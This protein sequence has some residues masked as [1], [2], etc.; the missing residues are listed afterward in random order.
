MVDKKY[1]SHYEG[2]E[3][4]DLLDK[5]NGLEIANY[6]QKPEV[7]E[8]LSKKADIDKYY[9][10]NQI[11]EIE[12]F[13]TDSLPAQV[14]VGKLEEGIPLAGLSVKTILKMI[15]YGGA[16]NPTLKDP[17]FDY[18]IH[19]SLLGIYGTSYTLNGVLKFDRGDIEP[20]YG[21]SGFR[22]G[23]PY[24]YSVND[25]DYE[26]S[27][28]TC[29]FSLNIATL[30]AGDNSVV[31]K[32]YYDE[33]EQPSNSLGAPFDKPYPAGEMSKKF[34]IIG[35][36]ASYSGLN[37]NYVEDY[38][39]IELIPIEDENYQKVGLFGENNIVFGYQLTTPD[40]QNS[41]DIQTILLPKGVEIYGIQSWDMNKGTWNW[42]YG[43]SADETLSAK[44]WI[45]K[46]EVEKIVDEIPVSYIRY[47]YNIETYGAMGENYFRFLIKES[48][49]G[50][51]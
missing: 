42:F 10:K 40:I 41:S 30:E 29:E 4:D 9:N 45:N 5:I 15:L 48:S 1:A 14:T 38:F 11:D 35:L 23:L 49:D 6:Y 26:V 39:S 13:E 21:T 36:T 32:V 46:G 50:K 18:E 43:D 37:G 19:Q 27:E 3:I 7:D 28:L 12:T 44:S 31:L 2:K 34:D 33:G 8:L 22:A 20:N 51:N 47:D 17:S 24:K 25:K 16:K